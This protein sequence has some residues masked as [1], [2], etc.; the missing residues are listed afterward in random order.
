MRTSTSIQLA[1]YPAGATYGPRRLQDY[2]FVWLLRGSAQWTVVGPATEPDEQAAPPTTHLLR[3]GQLALSRAGAIDSYQWDPQM[4]ST[5]AYVHF[6]LRTA[7]LGDERDWPAVRSLAAWPVLS[8]ICSYLLDLAIQPSPAARRRIDHLVGVLLDVFV[9]G[10]VIEIEDALPAQ[11]AVLVDGVRDAWG[12]EGVRIVTTDELAAA[13]NVSAG[14]LFRLFREHFG[15]GPARALELIRLSRAATALQRSN[16]TIADIAHRSG[17]A[18]PYHFS[19][20][21]A[22]V[23]GMPPGAFRRQPDPGD[24]YE[25]VRRAGLL[26]IARALLSA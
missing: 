7:D 8:G 11:L 22:S 2:E 26:P 16:A 12:R 13:G 17:F 5:H 4:D 1:D 24:P 9:A 25:Y 14:H 21:F 3:A 18:N 23:Y 10:P 19:R 20:R 6:R 15:C